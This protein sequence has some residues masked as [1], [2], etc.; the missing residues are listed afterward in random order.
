MMLKYAVY[1]IANILLVEI[2]EN[3]GDTY[4]KCNT[5]PIIQHLL[6]GSHFISCIAYVTVFLRFLT[7]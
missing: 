6:E 7:S 5:F 1:C 3:P 2:K 4:L